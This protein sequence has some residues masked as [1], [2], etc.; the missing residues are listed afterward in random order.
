MRM[1]SMRPR[2]NLR[3]SPCA[4]VCVGI[5]PHPIRRRVEVREVG[6]WV[7]KGRVWVTTIP[8]TC[9]GHRLLLPT[10]R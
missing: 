10:E 6:W 3:V 5:K 7:Q 8:P 9:R 4:P 1:A 2:V